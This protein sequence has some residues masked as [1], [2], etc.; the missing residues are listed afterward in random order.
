MTRHH[1]GHLRPNDPPI[2]PPLPSAQCLPSIAVDRW[3]FRLTSFYHPGAEAVEGLWL[4]VG[5]GLPTIHVTGRDGQSAGVIVGF[6]IDLSAQRIVR[7]QWHAPSQADLQSEEG[8]HLALRCLG[9]RFIWIVS[10]AGRAV[11]DPDAATQRPCVWDPSARAAGTTSS[12]ILTPQDYEDRFDADLFDRLQ[13]KGEGWFPAGLTAHQG[14]NR[15]LPNHYL[16]L[17]TWTAHRF[18][19]VPVG[20]PSPETVMSAVE[21]AIRIQINALRKGPEKLTLA[22]TAGRESRAILACLRKDAKDLRFVTVTGADR[23]QTDTCI[24]KRIATELGLD[25]ITLPRQIADQVAQQ[26]FLKR[27]GHCCGD[28]NMA[29]HPSLRPLAGEYVFSGGLGGEIARAFYWTKAD[30]PD[31]KVTPDTLQTRFG[32]PPSATV[33]AALKA[34]LE[35]VPPTYNARQ[36]LDLAYLELRLGPWAMA[37]FCAD[38]TVVRY[39]PMITY[40]T[41]QYMCDLPDDWKIGR[42]L[43]EALVARNWPEL[44]NFPY[45]SLGLIRDTLLR[46]QR[47]GRDPRLLIKKL[48]QWRFG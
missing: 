13:I 21:D 23:H 42:K 9:G 22:L 6:P 8:I 2:G 25:H 5:A 36:I 37:Q 34:W 45:N 28:S 17:A 48:R 3:Q 7:G 44:N 46:A 16:D 12:A 20:S 35:N 18:Q 32:L 39:A 29:Y 38:P 43:N 33:R 1:N 40:D 4:T 11:L 24:A 27:A 14:V 47:I 31:M 41:V 26:L 10:I 30:A 19:A 15:L